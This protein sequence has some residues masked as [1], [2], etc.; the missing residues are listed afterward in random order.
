LLVAKS[1]RPFAGAP[2]KR[3]GP[4]LQCRV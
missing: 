2:V 3:V 1:T 4:Y